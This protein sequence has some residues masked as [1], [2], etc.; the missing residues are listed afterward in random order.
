MAHSSVSESE[1]V[2][3]WAAALGHPFPLSIDFPA[4]FHSE[5]RVVEHGGRTYVAHAFRIIGTSWVYVDAWEELDGH[6]TQTSFGGEHYWYGK[7]TTR[8]LPAAVAA[9]PYM[10]EERSAACTAYW[11]QLRLLAVAVCRVGFPEYRTVP[12]RAG[13]LQGEAKA[14]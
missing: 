11:A 8:P 10:T 1:M 4:D 3:Q 5:H 9:L 2:A 14:L 6:S 12:N 7:V 13:E